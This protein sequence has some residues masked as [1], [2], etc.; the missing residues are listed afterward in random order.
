[1]K[2][3]G[4][5]KIEPKVWLANERTFLKWQHICILLGG[6]AVGLYSAAG[7]NRL[8][9]IM[10]VAYILIAAFAGI[11]GYGMLR[12]RR[13]MISQRSGKDF[14]NMIGPII[15]SAALIVALILNFVLQVC[16]PCPSNGMASTDEEQVACGVWQARQA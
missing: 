6:L 4:E 5:L 10:G 7:M 16:L 15:V 8:A 11:W 2:N 12:I 3:A 14:D 1:M 13:R 9:Q